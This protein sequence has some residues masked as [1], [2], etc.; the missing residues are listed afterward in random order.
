MLALQPLNPESLDGLTRAVKFLPQMAPLPRSVSLLP[1]GSLVITKQ[2]EIK[3]HAR[4]TAGFL[5]FMPR[6]PRSMLS[7][8]S[9]L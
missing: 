8:P 3:L 2:K 1:W 7:S 4:W 5:M 9:W 6:Q